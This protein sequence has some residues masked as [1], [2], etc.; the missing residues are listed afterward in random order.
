M[1]R[2]EYFGKPT[3]VL[4]DHVLEHPQLP[5]SPLCVH[6]R[7]ERPRNLLDCNLDIVAIII[8]LDIMAIMIMLLRIMGLVQTLI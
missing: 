1:G 3:Y 2:L 4:M 5:V 7:L 8:M 6:R